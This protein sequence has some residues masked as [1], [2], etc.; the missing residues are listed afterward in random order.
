M[1]SLDAAVDEALIAKARDYAREYMTR[2]DASHDFGHVERVERLALL[3]HGRQ[4]QQ[5]E[6]KGNNE[7]Q[8]HERPCSRAIIILSALLH[9]VGDKKY[10]APDEDASRLVYS[11]LHGLGAPRAVA[12][13]VQAVCLGVSYSSEVRDP[14]R[15]AALVAEHPE[16]AV[17]QDADRLDALGAV[18]I[19][20]AFAFGGARNRSLAESVAH[21]DDKLLR[22]QGMMKTRAGRELASERTARLRLMRQW[23]NEET[24]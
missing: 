22:L 7:Q 23:W 2:Y 14:G 5:Q 21:F 9:D 10:L 8:Q 1:S 17:V 18:G 20:R 19:A 15:A 11:A 6:E 3:L 16:L 4:Q 24:G 12:E 13:K